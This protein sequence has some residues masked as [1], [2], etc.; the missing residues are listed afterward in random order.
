MYFL[1]RRVAKL[2]IPDFVSEAFVHSSRGM[3]IQLDSGYSQESLPDRDR[4]VGDGDE[5]PVTR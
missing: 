3:G 1:R 2:S 4:H 5:E